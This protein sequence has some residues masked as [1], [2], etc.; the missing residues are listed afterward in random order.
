MNLV[1]VLY[2]SFYPS[3]ISVYLWCLENLA[4]NLALPLTM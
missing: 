4:K 2:M 3:A 1:N